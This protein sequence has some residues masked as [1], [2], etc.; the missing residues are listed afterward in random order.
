ML[1][2]ILNIPVHCVKRITKWWA[3]II[4]VSPRENLLLPI[5]LL[6]TP[7]KVNQLEFLLEGYDFHKRNFILAGFKYGFHLFSVGQSKPYESPNLFSARQQ[8]HVVDQK[9]AKELATHRFAE[10][11]DTP[12]FPIFRVSP[13]DIVPKN[14]PGDFCMIHHLSYPRGKSV[15]DGIS[16]EH[17]TV[18]YANIDMA[19]TRI[20]QS[21]NGSYLA[22]TDIKVVSEFYLLI[23]KVIICWV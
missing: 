10:P 7:A 1:A 16:H 23:P 4:F 13:L 3:A 5:P 12:P 6:P 14:T 11:F 9:L 21:G 8:P 22:K 2:V 15:N 20:K 17:S 19:I 18:H